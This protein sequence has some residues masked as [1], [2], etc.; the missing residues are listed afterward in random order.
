MVIKK[1]VDFMI[2]PYWHAAITIHGVHNG[3]KINAVSVG[4]ATIVW[5]Y[6]EKN[7]SDIAYY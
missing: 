2:H 1:L 6:N 5:D 4:Y 3:K 7:L